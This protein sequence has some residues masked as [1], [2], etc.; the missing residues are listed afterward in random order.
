MSS[1]RPD[2]NLLKK[3]PNAVTVTQLQ[4]KDRFL[5]ALLGAAAGEALGV[6]AEGESEVSREVVDS[7]DG[8]ELSLALLRSLV[9]RRRF[10]LSDVA[11]GYLRWYQGNPRRIGALTRAA[12]DNLRAGE[13]PEQSG[14]LAW[15][16]SGRAAAGNGSLKR[17]AALGLLHVRNLDGLGEAA[18]ANSRITHSDPRSVGGCIALATAVALLVR[19]GKDGEE[20]VSRAASAGG[21]TSDEVRAA[22]ERGA[23][24]RPEQIDPG[25]GF[26]LSTLELV[27]SA[28]CS[29][30]TFEQGVAAAV[31]RGGD[32]AA[33]GAVAGALLGAKL[34]KGQIPE[35]WLKPLKAAPEL[36]SLGEQLYKQL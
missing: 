25:K 4:E 8:T 24:K 34:G 17:S 2:P 16:D 7:A 20:A 21:E 23:S 11:Q 9:A 30:A 22:I 19:A 29:A 6:A 26:V 10:E 35:R 12:L 3:Y 5:G 14:A 31:A 18:A 32:A 28:L 1:I 36:A 13:A 27:F 33:N 15:E